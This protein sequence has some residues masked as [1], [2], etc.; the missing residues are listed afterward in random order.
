MQRLL[1]VWKWKNR[2]LWLLVS[3]LASRRLTHLKRLG[4][5][6]EFG[7]N[8]GTFRR[9]YNLRWKVQIGIPTFWLRTAGCL[10]TKAQSTIHNCAP[11]G[12]SLGEA[13]G[14]ALLRLDESTGSLSSPSLC[15][16]SR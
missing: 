13:V 8:L 15:V 5:A 16:S 14:H 10:S 3:R 7:L 2:A 6:I 1:E 12:Y 9:R 4:P 11:D